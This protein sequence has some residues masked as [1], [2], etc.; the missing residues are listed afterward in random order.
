MGTKIPVEICNDINFV[1][2]EIEAG[3]YTNKL[4]EMCL[5]VLPDTCFAANVILPYLVWDIKLSNKKCHPQQM[6]SFSHVKSSLIFHKQCVKLDIF[7]KDSNRLSWLFLST[8][9]LV[10]AG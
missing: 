10:T 8:A 4:Q 5:S 9:K 3:F 7:V 2:F 6:L 1:F